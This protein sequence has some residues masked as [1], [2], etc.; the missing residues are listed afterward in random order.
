MAG[1]RIAGRVHAVT[2]EGLYALH[3]GAAASHSR[4]IRTRIPAAR[5]GLSSDAALHNET[6]GALPPPEARLSERRV[7]PFFLRERAACRH[8]ALRIAKRLATGA[9]LYELARLR[10][11]GMSALGQT[12]SA[13]ELPLWAA[14]CL[15]AAGDL[16]FTAYGC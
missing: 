4:V 5:I 12:I 6:T 11:G 2:V 8:V 16:R 13:T 14:C 9:T 7:V 3:V 15:S 10:L 1:G